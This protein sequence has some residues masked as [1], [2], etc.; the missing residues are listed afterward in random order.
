M[1]E[2]IY[3]CKT[4]DLLTI[5]ETTILWAKNCQDAL[6]A[7]RSSITID[8]L[9]ELQHKVS[10]AFVNILGVNNKQQLINATHILHSIA[11]PARTDLVDF[12]KQIKFDFRKNPERLQ[13]ILALFNFNIHYP[14]I[15]KGDQE[16]LIQLLGSIKANLAP[17]LKAELIAVGTDKNLIDRLFTYADTLKN[18]NVT[19]EL[20]KIESKQYTQKDT[21]VFNDIY[22]HIIFINN[23]AQRANIDKSIK[24]NFSFA[25]MLK[26]LNRQ[27]AA[28][29]TT[30]TTT[31]TTDDTTIEDHIG[32]I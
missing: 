17:D 1:E 27:T 10:D 28:V 2:R 15:R 6:S 25:A 7:R 24:S 13:Q 23:I 11:K 18:A 30:T 21:I 22:D 19:Q 5:A 3:G 29:A 31:T 20:A 26:R 9:D 12:Y 4:I 14:N 8:Y 16:A 32:I